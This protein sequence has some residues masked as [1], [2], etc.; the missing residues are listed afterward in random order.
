MLDDD[1]FLAVVQP[2]C[3]HA[4]VLVLCRSRYAAK[5]NREGIHIYSL[6]QHPSLGITW[7]QCMRNEKNTRKTEHTGGELAVHQYMHECRST[8]HIIV[9]KFVWRDR[10]S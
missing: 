10:T 6:K 7:R 8:F 1:S 4:W 5:S 2:S 3:M 9:T